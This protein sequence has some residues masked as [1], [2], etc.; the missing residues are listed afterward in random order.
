MLGPLEQTILLAIAHLDGE[1]YGTTIAR[2]IERRTGQAVTI[3]A[4]YTTLERL[5]AKG[6][7]RA[8]T[9]E[10]TAVRGGRARRHY[11]LA[12]QGATA[13]KEAR[14]LLDRMWQGVELKPAR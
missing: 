11:Q 12:P 8:R 7:I 13:L 2:E 14:R 3:G 9:G 10:A 5:A 1:G 6:F 4:L